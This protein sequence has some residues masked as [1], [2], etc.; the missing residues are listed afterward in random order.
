MLRRG[1]TWDAR[2]SAGLPIPVWL[3]LAQD[4]KTFEPS[5]RN[6]DLASKAYGPD[7]VAFLRPR[8]LENCRR[9]LGKFLSDS[10]RCL[11]SF[12]DCHRNRLLNALP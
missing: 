12:R 3:T 5:L 10:V 1:S 11:H 9:L 8:K 6:L 2:L 7:K 4:C